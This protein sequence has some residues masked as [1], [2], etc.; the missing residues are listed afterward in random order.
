ML[1][2]SSVDLSESMEFDDVRLLS[3]VS[4]LMLEMGL[5]DAIG[6]AQLRPCNSDKL[7]CEVKVGKAPDPF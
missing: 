6:K 7:F 5:G 4:V 2:S 3:L 1:H